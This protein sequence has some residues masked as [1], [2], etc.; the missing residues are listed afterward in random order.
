MGYAMN[1][2]IPFVFTAVFVFAA[3]KAAAQEIKITK[4]QL[5][6]MIRDIVREELHSAP[7]VSATPAPAS[8]QAQLPPPPANSVESLVQDEVEKQ[9]AEQGD[10]KAIQAGPWTMK[11]EGYGDIR[12]SHHDYTE[13]G[14][15]QEGS[16]GSSRADF[17]LSRFTLEMEATHK[18][19][20]VDFEAEIEFEH[21]GTGST[22]EL[23]HEA[24]GE[25]ENE[26][27]KGGEVQLEELYLRKNFSDGWSAR[28]GRFYVGVGLLTDYHS[29]IDYYATA[30]PET[31]TTIIPG[32]WDEMGAE[33]Q[34]QNDSSRFTLQVVNGLDSSGFS[35]EEWVSS[36]HQGSFETTRAESL[37]LVGRGDF[38]PTPGLLLGASAYYGGTTNNR[39]A[40]DL[41]ADGDLF[42]TDVHAR[43]WG[44]NFR[45]QGSVI[46][47][48][49][50]NTDEISEHN[51][52][53]ANELGEEVAGVA[54]GAFGLWTELGYNIAQALDL[55][56]AYRLEPYFRFEYYDTYF[57]TNNG[58]LDNP[59]YERY[60]YTPGLAFTYNNFIVTKIDYSIR[61]FG[62]SD[63][64]R[65]NTLTLGL[66]FVY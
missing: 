26:T 53:G 66:G 52:E 21:G 39:P 10:P 5:R 11:F 54:D 9:L 2:R 43:Y 3:S 28:A 64:T 56:A 45:S 46:Y 20:G 33:I 51:S 63:L 4:E 35:A 19:S 38:T 47:G 48:H 36:G 60:V 7:P 8:K 62:E 23:D 15:P 65:D 17:D 29:P 34:K 22:Q 12:Y 1:L 50:Q 31:E 49:L 27:E 37:A 55:D 30:R 59:R 25:F 24:L 58:L 14:F 16:R 41:K 18:L 6:E 32:V 42:I 13:N 44:T 40:S 61:D 57:E